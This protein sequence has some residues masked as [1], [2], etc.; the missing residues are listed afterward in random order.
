MYISEDLYKNFENVLKR[1]QELIDF[2]APWEK[3]IKKFWDIKKI[4]IIRIK[5]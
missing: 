1:Q 4:H 5:E 3:E 2:L